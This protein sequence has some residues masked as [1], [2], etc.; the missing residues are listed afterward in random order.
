MSA[1]EQMEMEMVYRLA[2]ILSGVDD[3]AVTPIPLTLLVT[4]R[5][6][7]FGCRRQPMR[8]PIHSGSRQNS[9]PV[10]K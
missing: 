3:H 9:A 10:S 8:Q 6:G 5:N 7:E 1:A 2:A 4:E